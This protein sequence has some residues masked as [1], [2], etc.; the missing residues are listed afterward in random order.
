MSWGFDNNPVFIQGLSGVAWYAWLMLV[1]VVILIMV[2]VARMLC[3]TW[4]ERKKEEKKRQKREESRQRKLERELKKNETE[5]KDT[6]KETIIDIN[7][8]D[9]DHHEEYQ[10]HPQVIEH[11]GDGGVVVHGQG[12]NPTSV[13]LQPYEEGNHGRNFNMLGNNRNRS[14]VYV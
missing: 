1:V 5:N 13:V 8:Y 2:V 12:R 3:I 7:E 9:I 11:S 6:E 4:R 10:G 14:S